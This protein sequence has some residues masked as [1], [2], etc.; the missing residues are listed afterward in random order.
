[1]IPDRRP[2]V[3]TLG[4]DLADLR[5]RDPDRFVREVLEALLTED[6]GWAE[7]PIRFSL[8]WTAGDEVEHVMILSGSNFAVDWSPFE[9]RSR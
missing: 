5:K 7:G 2:V 9:M 8:S 6:L 3:D 1:M 4:A